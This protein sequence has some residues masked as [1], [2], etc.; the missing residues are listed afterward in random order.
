MSV[1]GDGKLYIYVLNV[2]QADTSVVITPLGNVIVIDAKNPGKIVHLLG[3]LGLQK[4]EDIDELIITHPHRD[5][6]SGASRL[7][8]DYRVL[9]VK[10]SPFWNNFGM[11]PPQ[12]Q[13]IVN[14]IVEKSIPVNFVSG[15]SRMYPDGAPVSAMEKGAWVDAD[16]LYLELLGP[17]NNLLELLAESDELDGNHL[18]IMTRLTWKKF[19][20]VFTGD[21]QMENWVYYDQEGMLEQKCHIL[22]AAHHGSCNG[23]QWERIARLKPMHTIVSAD[24]VKSHNLPDLIGTSIFTKYSLEKSYWQK[25]TNNVVGLTSATGT[26]RI[27]VT[28]ASNRTVEFFGDGA[29]DNVDLNNARLLTWESNPTDWSTILSNKAG[30]YSE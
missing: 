22:K 10:L 14:R 1:N 25:S 13:T 26:V 18:S 4:D 11:G 12:Y 23:T 3:K 21:A 20:M 6:F 27:T 7:L 17:P 5:H 15:Y 19:R 24:P 29:D 8:V 28:D 16:A 9:S 2:G 30:E